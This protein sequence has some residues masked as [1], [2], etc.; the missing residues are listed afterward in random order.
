MYAIKGEDNETY[1]RH[2]EAVLDQ[3]PQITMDDG[4]DLVSLLH[5]ERADQVSEVFGGTEETTTGVIRL[6]AMARGRRAEVPD[7]RR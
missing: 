6:R 1:Y 4:A 5:R 3:H 7:R 2:I